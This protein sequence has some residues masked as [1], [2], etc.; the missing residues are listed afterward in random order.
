MMAISAV[1]SHKFHNLELLNTAYISLLPKMMDVIN[2]K[3]F[4]PI[5]LL[6]NFAKLL[7]KVLANRL[8]GRLHELVTYQGEI[9]P[10]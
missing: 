6:H 10:G 8:A 5:S 1:W 7:T 4:Q 2:V 9:H 3:D